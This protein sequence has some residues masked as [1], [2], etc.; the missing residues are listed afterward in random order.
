MCARGWYNFYLGLIG[1]GSSTVR[2]RCACRLDLPG[3][4]GSPLNAVEMAAP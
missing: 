2:C 4:R 1:V 3:L